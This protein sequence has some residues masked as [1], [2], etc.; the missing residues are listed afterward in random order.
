MA[1]R[2]GLGKSVKLLK[3][4]QLTELLKASPPPIIVHAQTIYLEREADQRRGIVLTW[5][6]GNIRLYHP[7]CANHWLG[8][9]LDSGLDR[10]LDP[11][12]DPAQVAAGSL[13]PGR[14]LDAGGHVRGRVRVPSTTTVGLLPRQ[15]LRPGEPLFAGAMSPGTAC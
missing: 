1:I 13:G 14:G 8:Q 9:A 12:Q 5:T 7:I 4:P 2:D 15:M 3:E 10:P 6:T 11:D